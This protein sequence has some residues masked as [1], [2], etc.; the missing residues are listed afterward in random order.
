MLDEAAFSGFPNKEA[1]EK[2]AGGEDRAE[3]LSNVLRHVTEIH[4]R[5]F[6]YAFGG[7]DPAWCEPKVAESMQLSENQ[8]LPGPKG[9]FKGCL[10]YCSCSLLPDSIRWTPWNALSKDEREL[11]KKIRCYRATRKCWDWDPKGLKSRIS[12]GEGSRW[13]GNPFGVRV[14]PLGEIARNLEKEGED[15]RSTFALFERC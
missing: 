6:G 15:I 14:E 3:L 13:I 10:K 8:D 12:A 11:L 5:Q 4:S 1:G 9:L 7:P 2:P